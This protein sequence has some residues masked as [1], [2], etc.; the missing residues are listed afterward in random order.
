MEYIFI[1]SLSKLKYVLIFYFN[2][3]NIGYI[4]SALYIFKTIISQNIYCDI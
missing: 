1:I 3:K 4:F 2:V